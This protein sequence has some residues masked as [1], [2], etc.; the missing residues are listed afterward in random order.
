MWNW[1]DWCR[2][3]WL[4]KN[5][6]YDYGCLGRGTEIPAACAGRI[7]FGNS[8]ACNLSE[9]LALLSIVCCRGWKI[10]KEYES[11]MY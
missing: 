3:L 5:G 2:S 1:Q 4:Y 9:E 10:I 11:A 8:W 6:L 7:F